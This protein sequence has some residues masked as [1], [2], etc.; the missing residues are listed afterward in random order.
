MSRLQR[1]DQTLAGIGIVAVVA[2]LVIGGT[3]SSQSQGSS[4]DVDADVTSQASSHG[5]YRGSS[6]D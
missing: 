5:E 6:W 3:T 2:S 1:D 4:W